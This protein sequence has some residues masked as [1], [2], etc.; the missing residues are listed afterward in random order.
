MGSEVAFTALTASE[1]VAGILVALPAALIVNGYALDT[2]GWPIDP[3]AMM[4]LLLL[5][6]GLGA[7]LGRRRLRGLTSQVRFANWDFAGFLIVVTG[8]CGYILWLAAPSLLPTAYSIDLTGHA[9]L[10]DLIYSRHCLPHGPPLDSYFG[11]VATYYSP[12]SHMLAAE[13]AVWTGTTPLRVLH[14]I[15]AAMVALKAGL[16][17][18]SI[19]R[20]LPPSRRRVLVAIAGAAAL[21]CA[22]D[23]FLGSFTQSFFYAQVVSETFAVATLW[24]LLAFDQLS[25]RAPLVLFTLCGIAVYLTWPLWLPIPL[26][27]LWMMM[28]ARQTMPVAAKVRYLAWCTGPIMLVAVAYTLPRLGLGN[29]EVFQ[30]GGPVAHPGFMLTEW[31]FTALAAV[32][33]IAGLRKRQ[34]QVMV[35]FTG[36]TLLEAAAFFV[37]LRYEHEALRYFAYKVFF[38]LLYPMAILAAG[39][40]DTVCDRLERGWPEARLGR[41]ALPSVVLP[42]LILW[43]A[44][45]QLPGRLAPGVSAVNEPL[46][47]CGLWAETHLP[48]GCVDYLVANWLTAYWLHSQVLGN[49]GGP[50]SSQILNDFNPGK[51]LQPDGLPYAVAANLNGVPPSLRSTFEILHQCGSAGVIRRLGESSCPEASAVSLEAVEIPPRRWTL[52]NLVSSVSAFFRRRS[53]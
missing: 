17:Y 11:G 9:K 30:K 50:H 33:L 21:I 35:I 39:A 40:L 2:A 25:G 20:L 41:V 24:A 22:P 34:W 4:V 27:T 32:G 6:T 14:P 43:A 42:A 19:L 28:L 48:I 44:Y 31:Q 3:T 18:N 38:L 53:A 5:E 52:A 49:P 8:L 47:E 26:L 16:V 12:G 7:A 37:F 51:W 10:T 45:L 13:I 1:L 15:L 36:V 29:I 23:Y 46:Y